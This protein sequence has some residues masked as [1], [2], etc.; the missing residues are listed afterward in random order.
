M[1]K[2]PALFAG[3]TIA[4]SSACA[5]LP[6]IA[7]NQP[8]TGN[9]F[10]VD[11]I[12]T[13]ADIIDYLDDTVCM[14]EKR[15]GMRR[16]FAP[17]PDTQILTNTTTTITFTVFNRAESVDS[18]LIEEHNPQ[19]NNEPIDS[20]QKETKQIDGELIDHGYSR[21][22]RHRYSE[23][24]ANK[25]TYQKSIKDKYGRSHHWIFVEVDEERK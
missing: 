6:A 2:I 4:I 10:T 13:R 9:T 3:L 22:A 14:L 25:T 16:G 18:L 5:S 12:I 8:Q 20:A 19:W 24:H 17:L 15:F 21:V 23:Y 7:D 11:Q 1:T